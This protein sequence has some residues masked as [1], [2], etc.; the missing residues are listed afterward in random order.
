MHDVARLAG[1]SHQT[2]SRVIN[3]HPNV[4]PATRDRVLQAIQALDYRPN[5]AARSLITG[6]SQTIQ[7]INFKP[8]FMSPLQS[9]IYEAARC[10]YHVGISNLSDSD[11]REELRDLLDDLT[12][13]VVDGF[14]LFESE[15]NLSAAELRRLCRGVPFIKQGGE[16]DE[17]MPYAVFDQRA[18]MDLIMDHLL[19][20]G[21]RKIAEI[22]GMCQNHDARVRHHTFLSRMES[23]GLQPGP[24][25]EGDF[26]PSG[27][28]ASAC[29]LLERDRSFTALVC[30]NDETATGALRALH[31][32]G[33]RVPQDVSVVGFDDTTVVSYLEPP[34]TTIR[35]DF[36]IQGR[37][38]VHAL[39]EMISNPQAP[40]PQQLI[41]PELVIRQS[42][43]A[44]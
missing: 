41:L 7:V 17:A 36:T 9:V 26:T 20:L 43:Q 6:R 38:T 31:E 34:L 44:V 5:R 29:R 25:I 15:I 40:D 10:G 2:V 4:L 27:G 35:Q 8:Y 11:S 30:G 42:T 19:G 37:Q 33:M 16:P 24:V 14:I 39:V 28:Y 18:G 1:V 13:R 32:C 12:S 22:P 3:D 23:A 21:H